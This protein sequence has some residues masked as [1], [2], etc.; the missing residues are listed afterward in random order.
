[1]TTHS[2]RH[3]TVLKEKIVRNDRSTDL[4]KNCKPLR[5]SCHA[6]CYLVHVSGVYQLSNHRAVRDVTQAGRVRVVGRTL[7]MYST[8]LLIFDAAFH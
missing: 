3:S 7:R 1:M 8:Y 4:Q 6:C 5:I 2:H